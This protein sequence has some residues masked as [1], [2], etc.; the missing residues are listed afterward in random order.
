MTPSQEQ[1]KEKARQEAEHYMKHGS[2]PMPFKYSNA[3][4]HQGIEMD[5]HGAE[6]Q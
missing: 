5:A 1:Q 2:M 6:L 4:E 3:E